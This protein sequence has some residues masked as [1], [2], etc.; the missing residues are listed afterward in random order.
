MNYLTPEN[1]GLLKINFVDT[2][3]GKVRLFSKNLSTRFNDGPASFS[4]N[5]DTIYFSR[6]LKV[7]VA[8]DENSPR[9]KLG[10]FTAVLE[11]DRLGKNTWI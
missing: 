3:S 9:N 6:N 5:G 4:K 10:I 2:V 8:I 1:K 7:D 11:N